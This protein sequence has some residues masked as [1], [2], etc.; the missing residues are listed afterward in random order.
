M[1]TFFMEISEI[2]AR[3]PLS[4]ILAHYGFK[5]DRNNRL[6]CPWHNDKTP[7]LQIYLSTNTWT[8]FS[9][10]C[11][12]GSG[13][14]IDFIM[15]MENCT[16]HE[17]IMKA[18]SLLGYTPTKAAKPQPTA[19]YDKLFQQLKMNFKSGQ[20]VEYLQQRNLD[21]KKIEIGYNVNTWPQLKHCL[22]FPLRNPQN[23]IISFYGRSV[24]DK[25]NA[26][27][28]YLK[29]RSGLYPGYP[30]AAAK[31]LILTEAIIDAATLL[32]LDLGHEVLSLYGTNGL[33][34]EHTEA[35]SQLKDLVEIIFFFDGDEAGRKAIEKWTT[36]LQEIKPR[37]KISYVKTPEG[38]DVNSLSQSHEPEI[39][40]HLLSERIELKDVNQGL[41]FS[42]ESSTEK[43]SIEKRKVGSNGRFVKEENPFDSSNPKNLHYRGKAE[44]YYIKGGI[45]NGL[46]SM[47][48]SLQ[49]L[50]DQGE[51]YRSKL[52]LYEYKQVSAVAKIA[53]DKLQINECEIENDLAKLTQEMEEW[54]HRMDTDQEENGVKKSIIVPP[55]ESLRCMDFLKRPNLL[56]GINDLIGKSGIIGEEKSRIFLFVIASSYKMEDTL[57]ALVQGS[58]GSGKTHLIIKISALIP[59]EN[60]I[61][62]TRITDS[63]LYNYGENELQNVLMILEDLDGLKEDA[64]L[65]FRELQSRGLL[66][67][68]TSIKDDSGNI[69]SHIRTVRG[70]IASLSATTKGAIYE[71]NMSRCFLIAV[72]ESAGQTSKIIEHQN[73]RASGLIKKIEQNKIRLFLQNCMRLMKPYEVINPYAGKIQL[74]Q[75]ADKIRRLNELFQAFIKQVTLI[76]QYQRTKDKQGRLITAKEDI[77]TAIE[78]MF[79][80]I[81]LKVDELDGS[82]RQFFEQLKEYL[83]G[84]DTSF[85]QREIRQG[86]RISKTQL[87]RYIQDL[88][89]LEYLEQTGGSPNRGYRYKISYWD[90]IERLRKRIQD[91]LNDQLDKL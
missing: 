36:V 29:N 42:I 20:A 88:I 2:K 58:S 8:C 4:Q 55:E 32:Q 28:F 59:E 81:V 41:L 14:Q 31:T 38:E 60:V 49:I 89:D 71:D 10:N 13:D 53:A 1:S 82:L 44:T 65:A 40:H 85:G 43:S 5:P 23:E 18:K 7:S 78:I 37:A 46:D 83:Q 48:I 25:E 70:P 72:D 45:K 80:S 19:D 61:T 39:F 73:Q 50:N 15:R 69:R 47:K 67:S 86:L 62:L 56:K 57:H 30:K 51:D 12:A 66:S 35:V 24:Y 11:N 21:R 34:G 16:K 75:E 26:K 6:C 87:Q 91:D 33:T 17:A 74:P 54:R 84:K 22:I 3:L 77:A 68:S 52:D 27:H 9:S 79:E 90:N 76:N 64:F 63:S